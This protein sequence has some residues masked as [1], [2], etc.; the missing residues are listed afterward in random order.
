MKKAGKSLGIIVTVALT[1]L[2]SATITLAASSFLDIAKKCGVEIV[3]DGG[4]TIWKGDFAGKTKP[5]GPLAGK[6]IGLLVACEF[7]DWQAY[8]LSE[9]VAE[10][11]GT[12]QFI[13]SNN[14]L[15]KNTRPMNGIRIP[16]GTW[17]LTLTEG[18]D[19][20]GINGARVEYPVVIKDDPQHGV[21][22]GKG[23]PEGGRSRE[24]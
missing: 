9:Y 8:Y 5:K 24:I 14:H 16:R 23:R 22:G 20:L 18:M 12:A 17:G 15:W 11:G 7:S 2:L 13:M 1:F 10:F 21:S 19:G 4:A 3:Q 6:K